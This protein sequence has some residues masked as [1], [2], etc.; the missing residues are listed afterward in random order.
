MR[1]SQPS[2]H[3]YLRSSI[4]HNLLDPLNNPRRLNLEPTQVILQQC[5]PVPHA[6]TT[7]DDHSS[8]PKLSPDMLALDRVPLFRHFSTMSH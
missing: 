6:G 4:A 3:L 1:K 7:A 5:N 8:D 2:H